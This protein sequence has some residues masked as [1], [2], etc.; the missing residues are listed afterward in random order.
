MVMKQCQSSYGV[1]NNADLYYLD[2]L[3]YRYVS[4]EV[5]HDSYGAINQMDLI[6]F[7]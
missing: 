7:L 6:G 2:V 5:D 4:V 3:S 1:D